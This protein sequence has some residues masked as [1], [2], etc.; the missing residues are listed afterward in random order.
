[1]SERN[2]LRLPPSAVDL[3]RAAHASAMEEL[4]AHIAH[5]ANQPLAAIA[6]NANACLRWLQAQPPNIAE[7]RAAAERIVRDAQRASDVIAETR[8]F[9]GRDSRDTEA[10]DMASVLR[11]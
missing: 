1:M 6:A 4:V 10:L 8:T 9:L 5:E 7:A 2:R 11:D 3:E